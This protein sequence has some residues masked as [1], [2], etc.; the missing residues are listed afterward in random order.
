MD[1]RQGVI[2]ALMTALI[3]GISVYV[4]GIAVK[5]ADPFAYT[6][7]KNA[8]SLAF[9]ALAAIALGEIRN[10]RNVKRAS[11]PLLVLIG[12]IGGSVPFL[13]FF[14][15]LKLGGP[16][17]SSFIFRSLFVFA[18]VFGYLILRERPSPRDFLGGLLILAG[19]ALLVSGDLVF[20]FGQLLVLAATVLWALEYTV[21][22]KVLSDVHPRVVMASRMFFGSIIILA[23]LFTSGSAAALSAL[24]TDILLWL[25]VT[26]L[27]LFGFLFCWYQSLK[28]LP[29]LTATSILALGGVIT[30]ALEMFFSSRPFTPFEGLGLILIVLG[31]AAVVSI[32][33]LYDALREPRKSLVA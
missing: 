23:F 10:F 15:G 14:Y 7:L 16:S 26:S 1:L 17:V 31:V 4:N 13:L 27:L 33:E 18:G 32:R 2:L 20:G 5:T 3:S 11:I 29:V 19:N 25:A 9:I 8:G 6:F 30:A 12:I 28:S 21:S 24:T 22:R